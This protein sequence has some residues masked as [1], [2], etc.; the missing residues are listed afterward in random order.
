MIFAADGGI[1]ADVGRLHWSA[2]ST[3]GK[4]GCSGGKWG[5][6]ASILFLLPKLTQYKQPKALPADAQL[7]QVAR[8]ARKVTGKE[9]GRRADDRGSFGTAAHNC[10]SQSWLNISA[11]QSRWVRTYLQEK[12]VFGSAAQVASYRLKGGRKTSRRA[13]SKST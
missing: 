7:R 13:R 4:W 11:A 10:Y 8:D 5:C 2:S 1:K 6:S 12:S 3:G 9:V